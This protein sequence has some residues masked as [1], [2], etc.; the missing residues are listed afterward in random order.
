MRAGGD[1]RTIAAGGV[2]SVLE[3][4]DF[5]V[6]AFLAPVLAAHFFPTGNNAT[7]LIATFGVF[8]GGYLMRP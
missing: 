6:Y 2:G 7:S 8:A 1:R 4:Y 5:G 3:W